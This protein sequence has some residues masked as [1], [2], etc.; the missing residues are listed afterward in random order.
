MGKTNMKLKLPPDLFSK[1]QV[2]AK[3]TGIPPHLIIQYALENQLSTEK[4]STNDE[5][6][7][8][9]TA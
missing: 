3:A 9:E 1:I 7:K 6:D 2:K 4:V 8:K 5:I